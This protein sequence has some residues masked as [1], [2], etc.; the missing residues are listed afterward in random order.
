MS[1]GSDIRL[2]P[3]ADGLSAAEIEAIDHAVRAVPDARA[4]GIEALLVVQQHR[5][6]VS[7][8]ALVAVA[9]YLGRSPAELDGAATFANLIFRRPVGRHVIMLCDS[10]SCYVMGAEALREALC[11]HLGI[12]PG[13]TTP[14]DRFTLLPIVCLGACDHAPVLMI[15]QDIVHDV[16]AERLDAI[17]EAYP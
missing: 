3:V 14:D 5:R 11:A 17:L 1:D 4:A 9:T 12:R 15:D 6:W 10:V 8:E 13:E 7:D 2:Q 16:S